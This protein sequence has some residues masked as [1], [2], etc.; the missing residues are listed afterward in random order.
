[1]FHRGLTFMYFVPWYALV[2][3]TA[4]WLAGHT[5][6]TVEAHPSED[7]GVR[8]YMGRLGIGDLKFSLP[9]IRDGS[10]RRNPDFGVEFRSHDP[11]RDDS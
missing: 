4:R 8:R 9:G 11:A 2:G 1:M 7:A 6:L 3:V 10:H 5:L